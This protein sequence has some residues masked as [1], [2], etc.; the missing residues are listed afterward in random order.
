MRCV[1]QV[2]AQVS[3]V[4]DSGVCAGECSVVVMSASVCVE[5]R[6]NGSRFVFR[7]FSN[8]LIFHIRY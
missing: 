5:M 1:V 3:V 8:V 2:S 4:C 6:V 7:S